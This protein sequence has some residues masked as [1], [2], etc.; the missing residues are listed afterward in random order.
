MR[1]SNNETVGRKGDIMANILTW[2]NGHKWYIKSYKQAKLYAFNKAFYFDNVY[3]NGR[4]VNR[5]F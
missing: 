5:S 3:L 4:K 1:T 2:G